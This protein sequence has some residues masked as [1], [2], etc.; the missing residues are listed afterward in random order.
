MGYLRILV[1]Q[2][3]LRYT[4]HLPQTE[5]A[6]RG[7][8]CSIKSTHSSESSHGAHRAT[9]ILDEFGTVE[10]ANE[11]TRTMLKGD[12]E[13]SRCL[14]WEESKQKGRRLRISA[15]LDNGE[16]CD[17]RIENSIVLGMT[18]ERKVIEGN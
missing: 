18:A 4:T 10:A 13:G 6:Q 8:V 1:Y 17:I 11:L 15:M 5:N 16:C 3:P 14:S 2:C 9:V 12:F 7:Y